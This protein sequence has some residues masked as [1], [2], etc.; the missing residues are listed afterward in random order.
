MG[1]LGRRIGN[2]DIL[3]LYHNLK[4]GKIRW[5]NPSKTLM[6]ANNLGIHIFEMNYVINLAYDI[7]RKLLKF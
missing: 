6:I 7:G 5:N 1:E 4:K 2:G 3:K